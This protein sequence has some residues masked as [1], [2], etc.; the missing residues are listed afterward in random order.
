MKGLKCTTSNCEFNEGF[1]CKAG[2]VNIDKRGNCITRIKR[3]NGVIEQEFVNME[4]SSEFNYSDNEDTLI[5]CNSTDCSYNKCFKCAAD[6][7][8]VGEKLL[9]TKCKTRTKE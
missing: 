6:F 8:N 3:E 2:V 5:K 7:I 9:S 4:V 1:H